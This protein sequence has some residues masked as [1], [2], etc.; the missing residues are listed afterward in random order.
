MRYVRDGEEPTK[1]AGASAPQ[2]QN[3]PVQT[4]DMGCGR[5]FGQEL[6]RNRF[7]CRC[8]DCPDTVDGCL[9]ETAIPV[10]REDRRRGGDAG[11]GHESSV[12][13][14]NSVSRSAGRGGL[15]L[16]EVLSRS[17]RTAGDVF[18][19][20]MCSKRRFANSTSRTVHAD[21]AAECPAIRYRIVYSLPASWHAT[22]DGLGAIEAD[23]HGN[24]QR[25]AESTDQ[26]ES[27]P[28]QTP[29]HGQTGAGSLNAPLPTHLGPGSG[30]NRYLD[31][32]SDQGGS[33]RSGPDTKG[34]TD[35]G[36]LRTAALPPR[37]SSQSTEDRTLDGLRGET[38]R[39]PSDRPHRPPEFKSEAE[40]TVCRGRRGGLTE[41]VWPPGRDRGHVLTWVRAL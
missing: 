25:E 5:L 34:A 30:S 37:R 41:F 22:R 21:A 12:Q 4:L 31:H 23:R 3:F 24:P 36:T 7:H 39:T 11:T 18:P 28:R 14:V 40:S 20:T 35:P 32:A 16:G 15:D 19:R 26:R 10:I 8:G 13:R 29:P 1:P 38:P 27:R 17:V 33:G 2:Q 9:A 6:P